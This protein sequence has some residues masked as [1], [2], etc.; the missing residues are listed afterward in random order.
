VGTVYGWIFC[1]HQ[2]G[3]ASASWFGGFIRDS[4]GSYNAAFI[5]GGGV[6]IAGAILAF[7]IRFRRKALATNYSP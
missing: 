4:Y 2:L 7:G 6:A 3:A 1:A 5:V